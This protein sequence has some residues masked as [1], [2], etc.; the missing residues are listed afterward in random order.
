MTGSTAA[1]RNSRRV[2]P[3]APARRYPEVME[4]T[5][6]QPTMTEVLADMGVVVTDEGRARARTKLQRARD[7]VDPVKRAAL[8]ARLGL[9]PKS[10]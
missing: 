10:A 2:L 4:H 5:T 7:A 6:A 8:K 3:Q 9:T 1:R